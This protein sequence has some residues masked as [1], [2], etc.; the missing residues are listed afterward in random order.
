V[1]LRISGNPG[2]DEKLYEEVKAELMSGKH[3][4]WWEDKLKGLS[5]WKKT[6]E[7]VYCS[8]EDG[9][10]CVEGKCKDCGVEE[11]RKKEDLDEACHPLEIGGRRGGRQ[12]G[13]GGGDDDGKGG[14]GDKKGMKRSSGSLNGMQ[15]SEF[16]VLL[17]IV[18]STILAMLR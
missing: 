16:T 10:V 2:E 4:E 13:G 7:E 11:V 17:G 8:R 9:L 12:E 5:E 15:L 18:C 6:Y 14:D 3:K 1:T